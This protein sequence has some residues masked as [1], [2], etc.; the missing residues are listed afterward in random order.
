VP[1]FWIQ[2]EDR[3]LESNA[4]EATAYETEGGGNRAKLQNF[5]NVENQVRS[6]PLLL[7]LGYCSITYYC[8][9]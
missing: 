2:R 3:T 5:H 7:N 9:F 1:G 8:I 6:D 4:T